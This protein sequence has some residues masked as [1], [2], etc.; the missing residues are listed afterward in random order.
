MNILIVAIGKL[1]DSPEKELMEQ[2][3]KRLRSPIKIIEFAN[4]QNKEQ[5]GELLL[6]ALPSGSFVVGLDEKG[7]QLSSAEFAQEWQK[8]QLDAPSTLAFLIGGA[9]GLSAEVKTRANYLWS[10]GK[11]T[12]PHFLVRGLLMEQIYRAQQ[13]L[14][15]HPYHRE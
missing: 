3:R 1:K 12:W 7:K 14:A 10:L 9:D 4:Q 15:G 2:Y 11:L 6:S 5:E 8:W 13:I